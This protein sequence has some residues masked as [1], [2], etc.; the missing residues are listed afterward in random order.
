MTFEKPYDFTHLRAD[1][2]GIFFTVCL[3]KWFLKNEVFQCC[4]QPQTKDYNSL[5]SVNG[6]NSGLIKMNLRAHFK[7]ACLLVVLSYEGVDRGSG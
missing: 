4:M 3:Q 6:F 1:Y 2:R 5:I 7:D